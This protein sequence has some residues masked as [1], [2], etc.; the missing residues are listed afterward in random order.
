MCKRDP[1]VPHCVLVVGGGAAA[2]AAVE[3]LRQNGFKGRI[4]MTT[5]EETLPYDRPKLSK[6][7]SADVSSILLRGSAFFSSVDVEVLL[8]T[9]VAKIDFKTKTAFCQEGTVIDFS[10]ILLATGSRPCLLDVP[11]LADKNKAA[12]TSTSSDALETATPQTP[13]QPQTP[14]NVKYLR[15]PR[16]AQSIDAAA[17]DANVV[18]LGSGFIGMEVASYLHDKAKSVTLISRAS[19]PLRN[20]VGKTVG[21]ALK[22]LHE[23][24]GITFKTGVTIT[25]VQKDSDGRV[26]AV[27]LKGKD[28]PQS[29]L[30]LDLLIVG[31]GVIPNSELLAPE[32]T[33]GIKMNRGGYV[34]VDQHLRSSL[35][36][37]WAAGD[38]AEFPLPL[39]ENKR[40]SIGHWQ[41]ALKMGETAGKNIA[42]A[43]ANAANTVN[44]EHVDK[45]KHEELENNNKSN[46]TIFESI[47]FF[48]TVQYGKSLRYAGFAA[49]GYTDVV[50]HGELSDVE[51]IKFVAFYLFDDGNGKTRVVAAASLN[52][53]PLVAKF[54]D[55][56][57][58]KRRVDVDM[59][60]ENPENILL[61]N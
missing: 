8:K 18:I 52:W 60:R 49:Q 59:I 3:A 20:V 34:S 40:V 56:L 21:D 25:A 48:W 16:D 50:L 23:S 61:L 44:D 41:M 35:P 58:N 1:N 15:T 37:V 30:F 54:A 32:E 36:F 27:M 46:L 51:S 29:V 28:K 7:M 47:P 4:V 9:R 2:T 31:A 43:I 22:R 14:S 10:H 33:T 11:G 53:D 39:A 6:A 19:V 13:P 45:S 5:E 26:T 24:K 17:K 12:S 55:L 42:R 38:V 57:K